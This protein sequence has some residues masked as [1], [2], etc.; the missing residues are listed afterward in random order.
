MSTD[1]AKFSVAE[2]SQRLERGDLSS[3]RVVA[4]CLERIANRDETVK[5]W[6][7]LDP[8]AA[9]DA[10][11]RC[12]REPRRSP[13]H[14][15]PVGIKDIMDTKDYP[16]EY[17]TPIYKGWRPS[18]D[19]ACVALLKQAGAVVL[20]K[21]RTTEL[22]AL[23]PTVTTNPHNPEHTPGG[24]SS[25]SAAAVA[26]GM[27]PVALGTQTFGSVI[28]PAAY[29][30]V[31]GFKPTFGTVSRAGIK[32]QAESLDTVGTFTR[33]A[34]DLPLILG[35]LTSHPPSTFE[36]TAAFEKTASA[37]PRVGVCR[38]PAWQE[39][40]EET[41]AAI[42]GAVGAFERAGA[43]VREIEVPRLLEEALDAHF[44][45]ARYEMVRA[46]AHEWREHREKI[47][48][49]LAPMLEFGETVS[50][51]DYRAAVDVGNQAR[52]AAARLFD[53]FDV[54]LTASQPGEAP[55][56]LGSTG[57]P[58]F[59]R[60]WSFLHLPCVTL[61]F[62]EGPGGLPVGIQLVGP[63]DG[64]AGLIAVARWAEAALRER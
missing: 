51:A 47:S 41:V 63:R 61:P 55:R 64:D 13:M 7:F 37:A 30:G 4:A 31:V 62:A 17:G 28:R 56:G 11:R 50:L 22:A 48:A 25:G 18:A 6:E 8:G 58:I 43:E 10:A 34:A 21:T 12:D 14:G 57:N 29:C 3:E 26:D 32:P 60:L 24:S 44:S 2:L 46:F 33:H 52:A 19:A 53:D 5:A 59:N 40:Q 27:V 15:I 45:L 49:S 39:A 35:G 9:L 42:D 16:T 1:P 36:T 54:L 23:H 38:G 20:G